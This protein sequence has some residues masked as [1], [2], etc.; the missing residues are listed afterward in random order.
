[1]FEINLI[2]YREFFIV[3]SQPRLQQPHFHLLFAID[4]MAIFV[5]IKYSKTE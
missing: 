1:M 4:L 3:L 2:F 5:K